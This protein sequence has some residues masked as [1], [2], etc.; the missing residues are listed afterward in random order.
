LP[1]PI[2]LHPARPTG[3]K[4]PLLERF[5]APA[6]PRPGGDSSSDDGSSDG[7]DEDGESG[8]DSDSDDDGI[9]EDGNDDDDDEVEEKVKKQPG[10][11]RIQQ[12]QKPQ[13]SQQLKQPQQFGQQVFFIMF[14]FL[15]CQFPAH[16]AQKHF[17]VMPFMKCS[18]GVWLSRTIKIA[19]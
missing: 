5:R 7:D 16:K 9:S 19:D 18:H 3:G 10:Q 2:K 12:L 8:S 14:Y 13:Q 6:V 17:H 15:L 1:S 11:S 4:P